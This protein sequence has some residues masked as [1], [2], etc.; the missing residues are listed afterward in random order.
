MK[1]LGKVF[2]SGKSVALI[3]LILIFELAGRFLNSQDLHSYLDNWYLNNNQI[4]TM[5]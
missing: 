2:V 4:T 3:S 5:V 1:S